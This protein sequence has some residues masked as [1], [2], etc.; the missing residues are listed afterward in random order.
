MQQSMHVS[1]VPCNKTAIAGRSH[2]LVQ[3]EKNE[4]QRGKREGWR[5]GGENH[6]WRPI[7]WQKIKPGRL[8]HT[9]L[10]RERTD[11]EAKRR[12]EESF[13]SVHAPDWSLHTCATQSSIL[14][15]KSS[16]QEDRTKHRDN[17]SQRHKHKIIKEPQTPNSKPPLVLMCWSLDYLR[18]F[19]DCWFFFLVTESFLTT[20]TC[21]GFYFTFSFNTVVEQALIF[22]QDTTW[23]DLFSSV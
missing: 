2:S 13:C 6:R 8:S 9:E 4:Q 14:S 21:L 11:R 12:R 16:L 17:H 22:T 3:K 19:R 23:L 7:L 10:E 18:A 20:G 15:F 5:E 1:I